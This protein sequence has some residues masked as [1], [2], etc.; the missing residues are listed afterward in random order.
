MKLRN[1]LIYSLLGFCAAPFAANAQIQLSDKEAQ[2]V[3]LGYGVESSEFLTTAATYTITAEELG[4]TSAI[5]LAD[6]LYGKL[7]GLTAVQ[8]TGF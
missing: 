4:R 2:K 7:L 8:N 3:D 6:A 5:S 1:I